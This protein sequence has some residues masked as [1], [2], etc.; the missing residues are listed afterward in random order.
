M[1]LYLIAMQFLTIIP[2]PFDTRCQKDDLGRS[3]AVFPLAGLTIGALLVGL[4][5]LIEPWLARPL[6]DALLI[7]ALAAVTGALHLDG[8]ADVCDG[9]AARGGRERFLTVMKDSHTGAVGAVGITLG[10]LLKWQ[11]LLA[12]PAEYKWQALLLFLVLSRFGQVQ[13]IVFARNARQDGLGS[14]FTSGAGVLQLLVAWVMTVAAS[15]LLLGIGGLGV[16]ACVM[17]GTWL[18]KAL[19]Q[20]RLGGI[21][22]DVIGC[23]N[24]LNEIL[25][26]M[27]IPVLLQ[28]PWLVH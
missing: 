19:F 14:A 7:A 8:L 22:G 3:L 12:V 6:G 15:W 16:L 18:L 17:A 13:T 26:L 21:T 2:L 5:W 23:I 9:L 28:L 4:N 10:L 24:E 25:A 20:C 27:L 1:R 11:A